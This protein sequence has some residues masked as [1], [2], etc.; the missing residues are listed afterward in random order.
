MGVTCYSTLS[1]NSKKQISWER[2]SVSELQQRS[3]APQAAVSLEASKLLFKLTFM[4]I[5]HE[6]IVR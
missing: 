5:S 6:F 4:H 2:N 3:P 1:L